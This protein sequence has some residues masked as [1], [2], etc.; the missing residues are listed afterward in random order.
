MANLATKRPN[1]VRCIKPNELKQ[2][3]SFD[4]SLVRHQVVYHG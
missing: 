4:M 1:Y 3:R 2:P